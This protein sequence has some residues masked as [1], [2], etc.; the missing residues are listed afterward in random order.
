MSNQYTP[1]DITIAFAAHE[2]DNASFHH[3]QHVRVAF[4][5]LKTY[6]FID[7]AATYAKGIRAIATNAGAPQKFNL[8]IT[9]AFMSLIAERM[10]EVPD[11]G[12]DDFVLRFPEVMSK[13]L[14]RR[15]YAEDRLASDDARHIFLLPAVA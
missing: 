2:V 11:I 7:A 9:Y 10:A 14:L 3:A 8:T 13:D 4:D 5:L 12:F 15:W 1:S 6:D